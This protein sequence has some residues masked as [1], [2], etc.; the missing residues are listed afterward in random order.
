MKLKFYFVGKVKIAEVKSIKVIVLSY[1]NL[2]AY[3][4]LKRRREL[5]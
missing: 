1:L 5:E 3:N 2:T 4:E